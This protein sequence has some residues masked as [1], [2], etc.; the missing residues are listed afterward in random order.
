MKSLSNNIYDYY[1]AHFSTLP[2][3]KQLH[4]AS[5]LFLWSGD[6][7][8]ARQLELLRPQV[9]L[10]DQ[11][12]EALRAV[13]AE[14]MQT[15]YHGSKNAASLRAPYFQKYPEL[16]ALATVL[17]RLT[18]LK[19]IYGQDATTTFFELFKQ[20]QVETLLERLQADTKALAILSTHAVNVLYL[21][22]RVACSSEDIFDPALF[23]KVGATSY[24][25]DDP[26]ELQLYIYLYTHCIIGESKFYARAIPEEYWPVYSTMLDELEACITKRFSMINL[27]NKCE[28]LV[29]CKLTNRTSNLEARIFAEAEESVSEDGVFLVDRHNTNPQTTN[30]SLDLSEHRNVLYILAHRSF[31]PQA[32]R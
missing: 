13:Y 7:F 25:L 10:H 19:T 4:F 31:T 32:D 15:I 14:A 2:F 22:G 18:F 21:Y 16:R 12:A 8:G 28:F 9:T 3:D 29:C 17:F 27:D 26:L 24:N 11:P 1:V 20:E 30:S 5:R 23:L 6:S